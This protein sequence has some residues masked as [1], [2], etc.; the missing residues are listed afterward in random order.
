MEEAGVAM[1]NCCPVDIGASCTGEGLTSIEIGK[2]AENVFAAL[3]SG[4]TRLLG[5]GH[6]Q[7]ESQRSD[8]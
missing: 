8:A 5:E 3:A 7:G 6:S 4:V 2:S 1:L